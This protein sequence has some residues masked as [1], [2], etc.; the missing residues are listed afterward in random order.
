MNMLAH[1]ADRV[2]NRPLL[3]SPEKAEVILSVLA[4]RIG[5]DLDAPVTL[6]SAF[7]GAAGRGDAEI[8]LP[9]P[10]QGVGVIALQGSLVN[11]GAWIGAQSGLT[12]YEG[13]L[14]QINE[15]GADDSLNTVLLDINS[16]GGEAGGMFGLAKAVRTLSRKKKVIA[17]VNDMAASA[18]YGIASAAS[19]IVISETSIIG[20]IGVVLLHLDRSGELDQKGVKPTLIHAGA[21]KVDGNSF[22]PL[23]ESVRASMQVEVDKIY[24]LFLEAVAA[25]RGARLDK[26]AARQTEARVF[27]GQ[28][29]VE[30]GLADRVGTFEDVLASLSG[31]SRASGRPANGGLRMNIEE[32]A[33]ATASVESPAV[34]AVVDPAP[35]AATSATSER[36]RI[37]SITTCAAAAGRTD[38]A[39][40]LAFD[41]DL[42]AEQAV[43]IL[44]KAPLGAEGKA[45][46]AASYVE[47][48]AADGALT[49]TVNLAA[50]AAPAWGSVKAGWS[51][52]VATANRQF[53][54]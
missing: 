23:S 19:E 51:K 5:L 3:L 13:V 26:R 12:S 9:R 16:P 8:S 44:Q 43:A 2:L 27:L 22:G 36:V 54:K 52:A 50:P 21:H 39:S 6:A 29:A 47:G 41:T 11:R 33:E 34:A 10:S 46:Q 17:V 38:L 31:A 4:G 1:I 49:G 30:L 15:A 14:A 42:A 37:Q 18:A 20:S 25:G 45:A 35:V 24:N 48:K 32:N 7:A 28:D 53:E 40:Y